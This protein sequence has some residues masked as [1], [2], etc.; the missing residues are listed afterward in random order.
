LQ[1]DGS[2]MSESETKHLEGDILNRSRKLQNA[3]TKFLEDLNLRQNE[4][5]KKLRQQIREV[6]KEIGIA[7]SIDLILSD[8]V[9][10]FSKKI[11]ISDLVLEK[12]KGQIRQ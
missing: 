3:Q 1:R 4:E 2:V 8:G 7:E 11:D 10:Y 9:V 6:I 5:Y 12:L